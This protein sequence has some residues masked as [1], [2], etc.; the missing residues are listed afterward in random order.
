M[1][2]APRAPPPLKARPT[3]GARLSGCPARRGV[4]RKKNA[5]TKGKSLRMAVPMRKRLPLYHRGSRD[6][7][8]Q[9]GQRGG[10]AKGRLGKPAR[11]RAYSQATH[12]GSFSPLTP[13]PLCVFPP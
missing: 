3:F 7:K 12:S 8:E 6:T 4:E 10:G 13:L 11:H 2:A 1:W 9:K 5:T